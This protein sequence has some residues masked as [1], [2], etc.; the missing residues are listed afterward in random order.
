MLTPKQM[1]KHVEGRIRNMEDLRKKQVKV[2]LI[3]TGTYDDGTS[4]LAVGAGHEF[5][6]GT[7]PRRSFLRDSF[8]EKQSDIDA[9][10]SSQL[11]KV[12]DD[13]L[14]VNT[15]LGRVGSKAVG[16]AKM[17]FRTNGY[18]KWVALKPDYALVKAKTKRTQT[19]VMTTKLRESITWSVE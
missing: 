16:I 19:L 4:V 11:L 15:A 5:G 13:N 9:V 7:T 3:G 18:G 2:G 17:A 8:E 10:I 14:K 12:I 6:G 1:L